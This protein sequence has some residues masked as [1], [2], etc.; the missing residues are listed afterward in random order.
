M[1]M[2]IPQI[3]TNPGMLKVV[4]LDWDDTIN[5]TFIPLRKAVV[6][7]GYPV[8]AERVYLTTENTNGGLDIA[9]AEGEFMRERVTRPGDQKLTQVIQRLQA[10]GVQVGICTHRGFHKDAM[11]LSEE[12]FGNL[13]WRPNFI[14]ILD[15]A[16]NPDKVE[17]LT[18]LYGDNFTLIDDRPRWDAKH[19]LPANVWLMQQPWNRDIPVADTF[20]SVSGLEELADKLYNTH[21]AFCTPN[22]VYGMTGRWTQ[23]DEIRLARWTKVLN[24]DPSQSLVNL[25]RIIANQRLTPSMMGSVREAA[26]ASNLPSKDAS[27]LRNEM[28]LLRLLN[29]K[30]IVALQVAGDAEWTPVNEMYDVAIRQAGVYRRSIPSRDSGEQ[31]ELGLMTTVLKPN[32]YATLWSKDSEEILWGTTETTFSYTLPMTPVCVYNN[33][34]NERVLWEESNTWAESRRME[35]YVRLTQSGKDPVTGDVLPEQIMRVALGISDDPTAPTVLALMQLV[36]HWQTERTEHKSWKSLYQHY[37]VLYPQSQVAIASLLSEEGSALNEPTRVVHYIEIR[38]GVY[39]V[40]TEEGYRSAIKEWTAGQWMEPRPVAGNALVYP[41][42][43]TL[44]AVSAKTYHTSIV[45]LGDITRAISVV[46]LN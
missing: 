3:F 5:A 38:P 14:Y 13:G 39:L 46:G 8:P 36:S 10:D 42:L 9:L 29:A 32:A 23:D 31:Y 21:A 12:A 2:T 17:Y 34:G 35:L 22:V 44:V 40:N 37:A 30:H 24:E 33:T 43:L 6:A 1:N 7:K 26:I 11:A 16:K 4:V 27:V 20:C 15:P 41:A 19:P 45:P 28:V 18:E 25:K